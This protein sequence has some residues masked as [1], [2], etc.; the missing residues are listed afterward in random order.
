MPSSLRPLLFGLVGLFGLC[1]V[2]FP[3]AAAGAAVLL[4]TNP[5]FEAGLSG[6]RVYNPVAALGGQVSIQTTPLAGFTVGGQ[7]LVMTLP[8]TATDNYTQ[9][10]TVGQDLALSTQRRYRFSVRLKWDNKGAADAP[11]RA[12]VSTWVRHADGSYSG[13]DLFIDTADARTYSFEFTPSVD[14]ASHAYVGLLTNIEGPRTTRVLAE[15]FRVEDLGPAAY[16]PDGRTGNLVQDPGFESTS[17]LSPQ[18]GTWRLTEYDPT[19][20][21]GLDSTIA[22]AST[23]HRLR[24]RLPASSDPDALNNSWTGAYQSVRLYAGNTYELSADI[25]REVPEAVVDTIINVYL[26]R[27]P[28]VAG[29]S[30]EWLGDID[31]VIDS[32][33]QRRY[34]QRIRVVRTGLYQLTFRNFGWAQNGRG[35]VAAVDNVRLVRV[36]D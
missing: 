2:A 21:G 4:N 15:A 20:A 6:W 36:P 16:E 24:M 30:P 23:G 34:T 22:I 8:R 18:Q 1:S 3:G 5:G 29:D 28:T 11:A 9:Y 17:T 31:Y 14:G 13:K 26:Y 33:A 32:G 19:G 12:I 25:D 27:A 7:H 10:M 35:S